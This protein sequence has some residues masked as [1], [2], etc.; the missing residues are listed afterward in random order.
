MW[1]LFYD[2]FLRQ[3]LPEGVSVVRFADNVVLVMVN[4][5]KDHIERVLNE[6]LR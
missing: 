6:T 2:K 3:R 4:K 1:N 5:T